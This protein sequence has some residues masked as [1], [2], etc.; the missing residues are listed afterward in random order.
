MKINVL[1]RLLFSTCIGL[2]ANLS[3]EA[4]SK[5]S[6]GVTAMT[7]GQKV[8][9]T[10]TISTPLR[11][12]ETSP[13]LDRFYKAGGEQGTV[14]P[15]RARIASTDDTLYVMFQ[16][17]EPNMDHPGHVR[18]F[19]L[20]DYVDNSFL[21]DTYFQD[22]VDVFIR[23]EMNSGHFYQFSIAKD[24][25]SAGAIRG[26]LAQVKNPEGGGEV[27]KDRNLTF[28]TH[29][30]TD[31]KL[32]KDAWTVLLK[33][34]WSAFGGRPSKPFG[35]LLSRTR[36]RDSERTSP[37]AAD[38]DD[39]PAPD[40]FIET[41]FG[42]KP[43]I[44]NSSQMLTRLPSGTLRWQRPV[45]L[46]Y[47][48]TAEKAAIWKLQ[49]M[50]GEAT[51]RLTFANHVQL[52]QRWCDLLT[53]EG[54]NF[55]K[56]AGGPI[57][58]SIQPHEIRRKVNKILLTGNIQAACDSLDTYLHTLN[59]VSRNWFADGS[60]GNI[61]T[62]GWFSFTLKTVRP[63]PEG[64]LLDGIIN[65]R[66]YQLMMQ[67]PA[68]GGIRLHGEKSGYFNPISTEPVQTR[69]EDGQQVFSAS[70]LNVLVKTGA[71]WQVLVQSD[72]RSFVL[73]KRSFGFWFD[74]SAQIKAVQLTQ[75]LDPKTIVR[76]FGERYNT[77]NLN[78]QTITL[79][80]MDDYIGLT[81][82]LRNQTYKPVPF[83]QTPGYSMFFNSSYRLRADLGQ[84]EAGIST[85]TAHGPVLDFYLWPETPE[86]ALQLY[87][88][89]TGKPVVPPL[90][91]FK[92]W[93]GRTGKNWNEESP[94]KPANA[95]LAA[96]RKMDSLGITHS[97]VYAEGAASVDPEL[98]QRLKGT[99]IRVLTWWNSSISMDQQRRLLPDLADSLLP[100][101]RHA[102]GQ[103]FLSKHKEY[104]DFT[105]PNAIALARAFWKPRLD[106]GIAG[107]MID[108]GDEVPEDAVF[109]DGRTGS[110]MHNFYAYD[111]HRTFAQAF[112]ERR[113]TDYILFGRAASAGSQRWVASFAS[114]QRSNFTGLRAALTGALNLASCG[115]S[116]WGSDMGGFF[117]QPDPVV[118]VRWLEFST[119]SP[120]M[121]THGTEAREP[122]HYGDEA[123]KLYKHYAEVREYLADYLLKQAELSHETGM[124]MMRSLLVAFPGQPEL[125]GIDDE[126][127]LGTDLLVAPVV[128]E[129]NT[130][131]VTFPKGQWKDFW[132]GETMAGGTT[133]R[134]DAPPGRIP[135]YLRAGATLTTYQSKQ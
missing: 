120:L 27:T 74:D 52:T 130:R 114:D 121:R 76:G 94:G 105:H 18:K 67:F 6:Y 38:F 54:F 15:T 91:A 35:L 1:F 134:V 125:A 36:W 83:F 7:L 3:V 95:V 89:L 24:G 102:N 26:Q 64:I 98:H 14:T 37:V 10:P 97:A 73:D 41:T 88:N 86:H 124:P 19:K 75:P 72:H 79:W 80:G 30:K 17:Q 61:Q 132:T 39:R 71:G 85:L 51:T 135:V 56:E 84:S 40:L 34:P 127:L 87:T 25:Q 32:E 22:R 106:L 131:L 107:S 60:P 13:V 115:F 101:L 70:G 119:F 44:I 29:F 53:L 11:D 31:I 133:K 43:A 4:Q 2:L 116:I 90:W 5:I 78:G 65:D 45:R 110:E 33:L 93:M 128:H 108:F 63:T 99:D 16:C 62:K 123:V 8:K 42:T 9:K 69:I 55:R 122:W 47:P 126:Y 20:A 117:G 103:L 82:G 81:I 49:Q 66:P 12:W 113:G 68:G 109:Y 28:I 100:V 77:A 118:Y 129:G 48:S 111:Y 96:V 50:P 21:I 112:K 57:P 46:V 23:P 58:Y 59:L 92:P 104:V